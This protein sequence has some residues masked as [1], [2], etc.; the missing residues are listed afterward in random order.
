MFLTLYLKL[1]QNTLTTFSITVHLDDIDSESL[2]GV[3]TE[4]KYR[5]KT[6]AYAFIAFCI[7]EDPGSK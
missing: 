6:V 1:R 5:N 7:Y 4:A 3:E 2:K